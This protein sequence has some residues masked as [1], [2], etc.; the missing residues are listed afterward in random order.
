MEFKINKRTV[1]SWTGCLIGAISIL[2]GGIHT[3]AILIQNKDYDRDLVFFT[4]GRR[5]LD[6]LRI[7]QPYYHKRG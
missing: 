3:Y 4:F 2:F 7:T 5:Y 1:L 6:V